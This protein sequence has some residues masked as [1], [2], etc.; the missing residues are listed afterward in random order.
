MR[1]RG[2]RSTANT[3]PTAR[4]LPLVERSEDDHRQTLYGP[5]V[6]WP[7]RDREFRAQSC[8]AQRSGKQTTQHDLDNQIP[9]RQTPC[10]GSGD[11]GQLPKSPHGVNRNTLET[12]PLAVWPRSRESYEMTISARDR[13]QGSLLAGAVGDAL[14]AGIDLT[15]SRRSDASTALRES[16]SSYLH[17]DDSVQ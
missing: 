11:L 17:T 15:Q 10:S 3:P 1:N 6:M 2:C 12:R 13:L 7:R 8:S 5:D 4:L 14:R 16:R 9:L